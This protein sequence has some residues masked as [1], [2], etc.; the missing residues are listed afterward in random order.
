ML[1]IRQKI[2]WFCGCCLWISRVTKKCLRGE[3]KYFHC[4]PGTVSALW[5]IKKS[6]NVTFSCFFNNS[7]QLMNIFDWASTNCIY[8]WIF[9]Q[10]TRKDHNQARWCTSASLG[11]GTG[12]AGGLQIWGQPRL[13]KQSNTTACYIQNAPWESFL[14]QLT[15]ERASLTVV[16]ICGDAWL[17]T[18]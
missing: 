17:I 12:K 8:C 11:F 16:L 2:H 4:V 13:Y 10:D 14:Q 1:L 5:V 15:G 18:N 3:N 7:Y 9:C 6:L